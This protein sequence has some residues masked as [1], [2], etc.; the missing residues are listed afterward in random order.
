[1]ISS[2]SYPR[3]FKPIELEDRLFLLP[4]LQNVPLPMCDYAFTNLYGWR[5]YYDTQWCIM[6]ENTLVIRFA[7]SSY[8]HPVYMLPHCKISQSRIDT[9]NTLM[10]LANSGGDPLIFFGVTS[11]CSE[12]LEEHFPR[13]FSFSWEN[14][15]IDYIYTREKLLTLKGKKLQSKRNHIHKFDRLYPD[16]R[17]EPFTLKD[18]PDYLNFVDEWL[19]NEPVQDESLRAENVM[20][21]RILEAA[22]ALELIGGALRIEG[23]IIALTVASKISEEVVDVHVEKADVGYEGS[24]TKINNEFVK[25]LPETVKLLNREE[26]LGIPGLRKAK[27]SYQPD[28]RLQK[29]MAIFNP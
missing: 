20:I 25:T 7:N 22:E 12:I 10:D 28:L 29:G 3:E 16:C 17:Y 6:G 26:D 13:K 2:V 18:I 27:E 19:Q 21:H 15:S 11:P 9:I 23:K 14:A 5:E 8:H 1:M 4:K 24:Y